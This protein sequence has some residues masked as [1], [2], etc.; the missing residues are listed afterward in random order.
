MVG[1][2]FEPWIATQRIEPWINFDITQPLRT[3]L[4]GIFKCLKRLILP[5]EPDIDDGYVIARNMRFC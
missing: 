4:I 2:L 1:E 3:L 5:T